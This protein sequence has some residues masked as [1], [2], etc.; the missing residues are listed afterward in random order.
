M[1]TSSPNTA[2]LIE[3]AALVEDGTLTVVIDTT[4]DFAHAP[5]AMARV[6]TGHARGKVV[7]TLPGE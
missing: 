3:L 7:V 5:D 1:V 6:A 4:F 2:D